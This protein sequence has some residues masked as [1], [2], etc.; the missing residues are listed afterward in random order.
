MSVGSG[1]SFL[2]RILFLGAVWIVITSAD[3]DSMVVGAVAVLTAAW[4]SVRLDPARQYPVK[5]LGALRLLPGFIWQSVMGGIDV[6]RR[7]LDPR[8]PLRPGWFVLEAK[9][10]EGTPRVVV[11][12]EFSLL[13]GT[14]VAGTRDGRFLVHVLDRTKPVERDLKAGEAALSRAFK[15]AP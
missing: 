15:Q 7:A 11:G 10:P 1:F 12:G 8:L 9:V 2:R 5:L 13:P 14:L 6:A 3:A 4:L